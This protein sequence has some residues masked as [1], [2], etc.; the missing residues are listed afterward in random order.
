M[1]AGGHYLR[2]IGAG[3]ITAP[4]GSVV[5][6]PRVTT[7]CCFSIVKPTV[8]VRIVGPGTSTV[9]LRDSVW[10]SRIGALQIARSPPLESAKEFINRK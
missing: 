3:L 4:S 2:E 6:S 10:L 9:W 8:W 5:S 1:H 7:R